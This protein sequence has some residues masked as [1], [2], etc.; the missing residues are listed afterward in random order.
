M[1]EYRPTTVV[2]TALLNQFLAIKLKV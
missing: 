1:G 2:F